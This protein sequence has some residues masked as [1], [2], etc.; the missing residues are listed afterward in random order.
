MNYSSATRRKYDEIE[1][2]GRAR[3]AAIAEDYCFTLAWQV[4]ALNRWGYIDVLERKILLI[5][6]ISNSLASM[7]EG[8]RRSENLSLGLEACLARQIAAKPEDLSS[9]NKLKLVRLCKVFGSSASNLRLTLTIL[10]SGMLNELYYSLT[11]STDKKA[12]RPRLTLLQMV[13]PSDSPISYLQDRLLELAQHFA[14]DAAS[15]YFLEVL[16]VDF[17]TLMCDWNRGRLFCERTQV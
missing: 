12:P 5:S 11:G 7:L 17:P 14:A 3:V 4:A 8:V 10:R 2:E 16:G 1:K 9:K 15:W 13:T 6:V